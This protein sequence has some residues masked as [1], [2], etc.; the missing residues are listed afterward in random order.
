M[1][2]Q[3]TRDL[4]LMG[5]EYAYLHSDWTCPLREAMDG[6]T[7]EQAGWRPGPG[8]MGVWDIVLHLTVW[9]DN[10][11]ERIESGLSVRPKEGA[12]P[13]LPDEKGESQWED[14]KAG[15]WRSIAS[16]TE[17]VETVPFERVRAS[18]YGFPDLLCRFTH[19]A[20]HI[21]Q[22]TKIRECRRW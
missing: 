21:G 18:P 9:N 8:E 2:E 16:L 10:I 17:L 19:I 5:L 22:I 11:V 15:L 3:E 13:P 4:L 7:A 20:Y 6:L 14:A 12:W 1:R